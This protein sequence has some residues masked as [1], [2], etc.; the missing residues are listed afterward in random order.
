MDWAGW[1][2][3]G[4]L[5]TTTIIAVM[6]VAQ[7]AGV[8]RL[9]LPQLMRTIAHRR[10]GPSSGCLILHAPGHSPSSAE[11]SAR[12]PRRGSVCRQQEA[13]DPRTWGKAAE[14][15][16]A[17]RVAHALPG[18]ALHRHLAQAVGRT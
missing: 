4:L 1:A 7:M 2:L 11:D 6:I 8:T 18:P 3:F 5:A 16:M 12:S 15:G 13:D 17:N 9:G 14:Q 10:P